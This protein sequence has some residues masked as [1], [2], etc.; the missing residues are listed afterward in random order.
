MIKIIFKRNDCI[1]C[2]SCVVV[3]PN[4][5][6]LNDEDGKADLLNSKQSKEYFIT[7]T[8]NDEYEENKEATECC[9]VN[10]IQ[11]KKD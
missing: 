2:G 11:V 10:C 7:D 4:N 3:A 9:P 1:G 5:W 8:T 6:K